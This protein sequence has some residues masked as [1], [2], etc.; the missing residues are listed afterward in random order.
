MNCGVLVFYAR[1][2]FD[3]ERYLKIA[4]QSSDLI[5]IENVLNLADRKLSNYLLENYIN[6]TEDLFDKVKQ[7]CESLPVSLTD[8]LFTSMPKRIKKVR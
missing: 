4:P 8:S 3:S 1:P 2:N 7:I 5:I 6:R